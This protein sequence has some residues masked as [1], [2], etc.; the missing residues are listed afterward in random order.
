[1]FLGEIFKIDAMIPNEIS[2]DVNK[3]RAGCC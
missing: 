2:A 1:M 3:G